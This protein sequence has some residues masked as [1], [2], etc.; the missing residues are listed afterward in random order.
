M[1]HTGLL[2]Y[3]KGTMLMLSHSA[4]QVAVNISEGIVRENSKEKATKSLLD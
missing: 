2:R 1:P 3:V 4:M